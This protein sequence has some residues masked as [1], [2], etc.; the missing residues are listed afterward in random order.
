[1]TSL[2][3]FNSIHT[4]NYTELKRLIIK[5]PFISD[6]V[7]LMYS[8]IKNFPS[9]VTFINCGADVNVEVYYDEN[10]LTDSFKRHCTKYLLKN[11]IDAHRNKSL[12]RRKM[13]RDME[14]ALLF[15]EFVLSDATSKNLW[16]D[17]S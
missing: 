14:I 16:Y 2:K 13:F 15:G 9:L 4:E 10:L 3:I 7:Y 1:M 6:S 5:N 11:G 12:S 8:V 17:C